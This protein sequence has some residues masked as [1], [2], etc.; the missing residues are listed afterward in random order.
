V[1]L[2]RRYLAAWGPA[3]A[4]DLGWWAGL[5]KTK[6]TEALIACASPDPD[7]WFGVE[8]RA[9]AAPPRGVRLLPWWDTLFVTWRNRSRLLSDDLAP[10]I[11]DGDGNATSVV[12]IDGVPAGVWNLGT[13]DDELEITAAPFAEFG[14]RHWKEIEVEAEMIGGLA[15]ARSVEVVRREEAPDLTRGRRNLFLRPLTG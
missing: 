6:A 7:G 12:L 5:S 11:Y 2:A 10:F 1:E 9:A 3:T 15:G 4:A 13:G 8:G 14:S